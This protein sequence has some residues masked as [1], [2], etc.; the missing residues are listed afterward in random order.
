MI[1]VTNN[2]APAGFTHRLDQDELVDEITYDVWEGPFVQGVQ[3][4]WT[5]EEGVVLTVDGY[6]DATRKH[7]TLAFDVTPETARELIAHLGRVLDLL[8]APA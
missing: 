1:A 6:P 4:R 2:T 5:P 8:D 3:T 7:G